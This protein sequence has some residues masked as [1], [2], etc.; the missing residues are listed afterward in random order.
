MSYH[1][2]TF[3]FIKLEKSGDFASRKN[4]MEDKV[5]DNKLKGLEKEEKCIRQKLFEIRRER[6]SRNFYKNPERAS[7]SKFVDINVSENSE[8]NQEKNKCNLLTASGVERTK[9]SF[10]RQSCSVEEYNPGQ[11]VRVCVSSKFE[12]KVTGDESTFSGGAFSSIDKSKKRNRRHS[13]AVVTDIDRRKV[14]DLFKSEQTRDQSISEDDSFANQGSKDDLHFGCQK[15]RENFSV[16]ESVFPFDTALDKDRDGCSTLVSDLTSKRNLSQV[17]FSRDATCCYK[18]EQKSHFAKQVL[19]AKNPT[20]FR[21]DAD[22]KDI[23]QN[24]KVI[25]PRRRSTSQP[26]RPQR[27]R[28]YSDSCVGEKPT[29]R[30]CYTPGPIISKK[31]S[32]I[33]FVEPDVAAIALPKFD[34][35]VNPSLLRNQAMGLK[36]RPR[37]L[38][39]MPSQ[40]HQRPVLTEKEEKMAEQ[41][42]IRQIEIQASAE[43]MRRLSLQ[44]FGETK[45]S[46]KFRKQSVTVS[47]S[48]LPHFLRSTETLI[49]NDFYNNDE[50]QRPG[51][52]RRQ[53]DNPETLRKF[54]KNQCKKERGQN[55]MEQILLGLSG[56][57]PDCRY[58]RCDQAH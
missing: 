30:K 41:V 29:Y 38:P 18:Q 20:I 14:L 35:K 36:R 42:L 28:T 44:H 9:S 32:R 47:S 37:S 4:V 39:D 50:A 16:S 6:Y 49:G 40:S 48:S 17:N 55:T 25:T 24:V 5:L 54:V 11:V 27:S 34:Q 23:R 8:T 46:P 10:R 33:A 1:R 57:M 21:S 22:R 31:H 7:S 26:T 52:I 13:V 3:R 51:I 12:D 15:Y 56:D 19:S 45:P 2:R 43:K 58:L 53:T